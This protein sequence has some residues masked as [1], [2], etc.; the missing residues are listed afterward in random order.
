LQ[1][2]KEPRQPK[3]GDQRQRTAEREDEGRLEKKLPNQPSPARAGRRP[4][5][6]LPPSG[7]CPCQEHPTHVGRGDQQ[8]QRRHTQK[9]SEGLFRFSFPPGQKDPQPGHAGSGRRRMRGVLAAEPGNE[10]REARFRSCRRIVGGEA[11]EHLQ[12]GYSPGEQEVIVSREDAVHRHRQPE[13][14]PVVVA[15]PRETRRRDPDHHG[16]LT[17]EHQRP[18]DHRRITT[19]LALPEGVRQYSERRI[20]R[21]EAFLR[22]EEAAECR[23]NAEHIEVVGGD[24]PGLQ[25]PRARIAPQEVGSRSCGR[26]ARQPVVSVVELTESWIREEG[27][28]SRLRVLARRLGDGDET[29]TVREGEWP[30]EEH[31][32]QREYRRGACDPERP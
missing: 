17:V 32:D 6:H 11:A 30:E 13:L 20:A 24:V 31:V 27:A 21:F 1:P 4:N 19:E 18:P 14:G 10:A 12:P 7:G 15:K 23:A 22:R 25:Q 8:D 26:D 28:R 5:R 2:D 16:R 9:D 3:R 29:I